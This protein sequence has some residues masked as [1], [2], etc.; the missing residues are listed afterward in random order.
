MKWN[1]ENQSIPYNNFSAF[2]SDLS[3]F[4]VSQRDEYF[5]IEKQ[6][7]VISN[8]SKVMLDTFPNNIYNKILKLEPIKYG[9]GFTS[10]KTQKVFKTKNEPAIE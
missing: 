5:K 4:V 10:E 6:C 9:Y 8:S 2:Y 7:Q 3:Q 1:Q